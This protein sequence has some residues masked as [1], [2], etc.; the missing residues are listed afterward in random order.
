MSMDDVAENDETRPLAT[1]RHHLALE[2]LIDLFTS[3]PRLCRLGILRVVDHD[4][5]WPMLGML[6]AADILVD[7]GNRD[8]SLQLR[9][10]YS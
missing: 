9:E 2:P 3:L 10:H 8:A 4:R 6:D 5:I 1:N 7:G